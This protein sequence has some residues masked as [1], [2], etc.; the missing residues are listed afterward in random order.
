MSFLGVLMA[1]SGAEIARAYVTLTTQMP[2]VQGQISKALGGSGVQSVLKS[3][4]ASM[5]SALAGAVG[6]AVAA[7]TTK[8][9][10]SVTSSIDGA[11]K[12]VDTLNN[13]PKIMQNLGYSSSDAEKSIKKMSDS[14]T[15]LPTS[16]DQMAGTVQQLAPLT[17]GLDEA[18]NLSLALNNALLAGGK[19]A[20]IQANAM[21]Q[22]TQML[23]T[24][25]V[26]LAAWRSIVT[27]MPGQM[28]QLSKSLL[29]SEA[30]S[31]DLYDAL[32]AGKLGFDDFNSAILTLNSE[33]TGAFASFE[34]QARS[35]TNGIAT[36]QANLG[37]AITRGLGS[38]IQRFQ[39]QIVGFLAGMTTFVGGAFEAVG[40]FFDWVSANAD[41]LGPLGIG[42]GIV[43]TGFGA[44]NA[45]AAVAAAGGLAK[46]LA[47]TK[48]GTGVQAAFNAVMN[49]NPI[50]LIVTAI[51]ALVGG[52]VYFFT[53]T[54]TGK[55]V[56]AEFTRFLGE[57]WANISQF[58]QDVW[59]N[60]L[61]PVF[62]GIGQVLSFVWGSILKPIFDGIAAVATWVFQNVLQ[63]AFQ[64]AQFAF[65]LMAGVLAGIYESIIKPV[66]DGIAAV[67]TWVWETV[68][69][70]VVTYIQQ[71]LRALGAVFSWLWSNAI[72]PTIDA[73]SAGFNF[74][75]AKIISPVVTWIQEKWR[76]LGLATQ[77]MWKMYIQPAFKAIGDA[78]NWV[79]LNIISPVVDWI[80]RKWELLGAATRLMYTQYIK[81]AWDN[82][83]SIISAG[84]NK[85]KS[86]IDT[87]VR[88]IKSDPKKAF[89][90]ARDAIGKAWKG[91]QD[92]AK[93]P[94]KFVIETVVNGLIGTVNKI[95]PKGM[96]IP[97]VKLPKGFSEGGYTGN[98]AP[99]AVAGV[100]HGNEHVIRA[101]SR[102]KIESR[103][104][105]LLDHMNQYGSI[106]GYRKG[107]LVNPLPKG[108]YSVSQPYHGGH[109][110][111]DLAAP[112]G[113]KVFA[114]GSG[115]VGLAGSVNMGGN[116]VYIQHD[117]GLGT[118]YSHLSRFG[119]R[120][121]AK[122]KAGNVIGYVGSTGMSTG[123]HLHYM[124]HNP[125]GGGGNYGNH[126]NPAAYLGMQG[127]DLGE[128]GGAA[129]IL[130]GLV[131]WAVGKIKGA[132][133]GGGM[134]VDVAT[135]MA[136]D[137]AGKMAKAFNPFAAA[138]GHTTLYDNGGWLPTGKSL[139]ENKTGRPEPILTGSQWDALLDGGAAG[140]S[141]RVTVRIGSRDFEGWMDERADAAVDRGIEDEMRSE[142]FASY[143]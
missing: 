103:H 124:V 94:V 15:G 81:P 141:R 126:V 133:P 134:W 104:P 84:W 142:R 78:L 32:K 87:M 46:W 80:R 59:N 67:F 72:K 125:G 106:P 66:F 138:D 31:M 12:R 2:G 98:L 18:T 105:G 69:S 19:S 107:G 20:D 55:K 121:G 27:A 25:N 56:W 54:E 77:L 128:A 97:T 47:A 51:A 4:G 21:E 118:R 53:Q 120:V 50:M 45:A 24:G 119:T 74:I 114:A 96:Q 1:G 116:E 129:S 60:V 7:A 33:G 83:S 108:S 95:L 48:I 9:I 43:A 68:I 38:I 136:K 110:G 139:V 111:I 92:L 30:K 40:G 76:L 11:I 34:E 115:T 42:L 127:K 65:S 52:L 102:Q 123:P 79:W 23:S 13:F 89:E 75:W 112:S 22:Y 64:A 137:A 5:G 113:T 101:A 39:P 61:R 10:S 99:S 82:V 88:V 63:P 41:I 122:V 3:S 131:D 143:R 57:A 58:F 135:A 91:I 70:V 109:N 117:N 14:L 85:I 28:D 93:K 26:D 100:V 44:M 132:F 86:I 90:A 37:T 140:G 36:G 6:G 17:G 71:Y 62:E 49:A 35:A 130:D 16:L 29:G 8:A 73:I